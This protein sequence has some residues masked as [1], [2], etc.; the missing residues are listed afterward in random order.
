MDW[1]WYVLLG[2]VI[3]I[4]ARLIHPGKENMGW[5]MTVLIGI[6]GAI[7]A[8]LI[9]QFSGWFGLFSWP[10]FGV[11]IVLAV[12]MVAIYARMKAPK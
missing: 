3:G 9:G 10:G 11:A 2:A 7:L 5:I 12:V 1:I 6:G 8:G 4:I